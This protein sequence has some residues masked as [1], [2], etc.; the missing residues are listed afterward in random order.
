[1]RKSKIPFMLFLTLSLTLYSTRTSAD[2]IPKP[3]F[4]YLSRDQKEKIAVCFAEN[5]ACH[6]SLSKATTDPVQ[7]SWSVLL[8]ATIVGVIGGLVLAHQ[9]QH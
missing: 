4:S 3:D 7:D 5:S 8:T 2:E 9:F 1:M 6:E